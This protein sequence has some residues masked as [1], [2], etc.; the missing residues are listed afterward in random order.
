MSPLHVMWA[1]LYIMWA[2]RDSYLHRMRAEIGAVCGPIRLALWAATT[3]R[4]S[5]K[6]LPNGRMMAHC[7]RRLWPVCAI[8]RPRSTSTSVS[9][10]ATGPTPWPKKGRWDWLLGP[11]TSEGRQGHCY[12][13][14]SWLRPRAGPCGSCQCD[15]HGL[16]TGRPEGVKRGGQRGRAGSQRGLSQSGWRL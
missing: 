7:G 4:P 6:S 10:M 1:R 5:T 3:T 12:H 2:Q 16:V 8:L 11:Q 9:S 13:R 14:Q 15:R